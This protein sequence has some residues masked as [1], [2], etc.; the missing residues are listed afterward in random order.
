METQNI[1]QS[2]APTVFLKNN[3]NSP[4]LISISIVLSIFLIA[5][6]YFVFFFYKTGE[7]SLDSFVLKDVALTPPPQNPACKDFTQKKDFPDDMFTKCFEMDNEMHN[8]EILSATNMFSYVP[9]KGDMNDRIVA[10]VQ[11]FLKDNGYYTGEINGNYDELTHVAIEQYR[12]LSNSVSFPLKPGLNAPILYDI[13]R[14]IR[15][16]KGTEVI[17]LSPLPGAK[18]ESGKELILKI[19]YGPLVESLYIDSAA[20]ESGYRSHDYGVQKSKSGGI[21]TITVKVAAD[22]YGFGIDDVEVSVSEKENETKSFAIGTNADTRFDFYTNE[23]P[24]NIENQEPNE[25][26]MLNI[27]DKNKPVSEGMISE[28][29]AKPLGF[30]ASFPN[31]EGNSFIGNEIVPVVENTSIAEI[32]PQESFSGNTV[33]GYSFGYQLKPKRVGKTKLTLTFNGFTK[34][35]PIIV[36]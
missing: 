29:I 11:K 35:F 30:L 6:F 25:T 23:K 31:H 21:A 12:F 3:K 28:A 34:S 14:R 2:N 13:A 27:T 19:G 26:Y 32:I 1:D 24:S 4:L 20:F 7:N 36:E 5:G 17:V 15:P 9:V 8:Y 22:P 16:L 18:V 33:E 10:T